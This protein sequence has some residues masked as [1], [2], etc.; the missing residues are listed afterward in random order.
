[1]YLSTLFLLILA[2]TVSI[3]DPIKPLPLNQLEI[4]QIILK[5][6]HTKILSIYP[7]TL[8]RHKLRLF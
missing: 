5:G 3:Y 2:A 7:R 6:R 4:R 8:Q 1:M